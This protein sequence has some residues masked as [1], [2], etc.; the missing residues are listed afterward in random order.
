MK[1]E[2]KVEEL[3]QHS[4]FIGTPMYG[5]QCAGLYTK[6]TN[7]LSMLCST[8]QIPMKYYFLFNESLV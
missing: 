8:H 5:G 2:I 7:D 1:L 3:R 4:L 6:S